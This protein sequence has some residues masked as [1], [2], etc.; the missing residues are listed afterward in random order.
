[1]RKR[2]R[3]LGVHAPVLFQVRDQL[4]GQGLAPGTV[5]EAVGEL[6]RAGG[7]ALVQIDPDH[8]RGLALGH[9]VVHA[10]RL[11]DQMLVRAAEA[12]GVVGRRIAVLAGL[13]A[14]WGQDPALHGDRPAEEGAERGA[15]EVHRRDVRLGRRQPGDGFLGRTGRQVEGVVGRLDLVQDELGPGGQRQGHGRDRADQ[16]AAAPAAVVVAVVLIEH[17]LNRVL[18]RRQLGEHL[19]GGDAVQIDLDRGAGPDRAD[20]A[21]GDLALALERIGLDAFDHAVPGAGLGRGQGL[22][23]DQ[24]AARDRSLDLG[25][26]LDPQDRMAVGRPGLSA[27][28]RQQH[29]RRYDPTPDHR[30]HGRS[31]H[32]LAPKKLGERLAMPAQ[33]WQAVQAVISRPCRPEPTRA[34]PACPSRPGRREWP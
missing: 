6:V 10:G 30:P 8:R 13:V 7:A 16:V 32:N 5:V 27:T 17:G 24:Q 26:H 19:R 12:V 33:G 23:E 34:A 25:P 28:H 14:R 18:A 20:L 11:A 15:D 3:R 22:G 29:R 2:T 1:M 4:L 31:P 21:R 9:Q